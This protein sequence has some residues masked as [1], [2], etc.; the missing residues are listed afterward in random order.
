MHKDSANGNPV[1]PGPEHFL[2]GNTP[3][4]QPVPPTADVLQALRADTAAAEK[5]TGRTP[6]ELAK[7]AR[8]NWLSDTL[9][10]PPTWLYFNGVP[11]I[12]GGTINQVQGQTGSHKS[13]FVETLVACALGDPEREFCGYTKAEGVQFHVLYFDTERNT[14]WGIVRAFRRIFKGAGS[15]VYTKETFPL[16]IIP[17]NECSRAERLT[18][19]EDIVKETREKLPPETALLVVTDVVTDMVADGLTD[20]KETALYYDLLL[21]TVALMNTA[22]VEVIHENPGSEKSRGHQG[23]EGG[24]KSAT[25]KRVKKDPDGTITIQPFKARETKEP[26]PIFAEYNPET[27]LLRA[28][29]AKRREE[30]RE[31]S[32]AERLQMVFG[33]LFSDGVRER[34]LREILA[35][36]KAV[37]SG[38]KDETHR[39]I[40]KTAT[41]PGNLYSDRNGNPFWLREDE[42]KG[43]GNPVFFV[44]EAPSGTEPSQAEMIY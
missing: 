40:L 41:G 42:R 39:T 18:E 25:R 26:D 2:N 16:E 35:E 32:Q 21:R 37:F 24:N 15:K 3:K 22:F 36:M 19:F 27:G 31:V 29:T 34:S 20:P 12:M 17:L 8:Q 38:G 10:E 6:R 33:A 7:L 5:V 9:I 1:Q 43:R 4:E 11:D 28:V 30:K 14:S 23:T 44:R 13:R